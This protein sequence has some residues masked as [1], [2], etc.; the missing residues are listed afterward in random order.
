MLFSL[1]SKSI[2][3]PFW[4]P[5]KEHNSK[6]E[7]ETTVE[8]ATHTVVALDS[9]SAEKFSLAENVPVLIGWKHMTI[10]EV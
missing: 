3:I 7:E 10:L 6:A 1:C 9:E 8:E 4:H 2:V 5:W